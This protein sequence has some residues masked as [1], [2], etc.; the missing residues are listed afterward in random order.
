MTLALSCSCFLCFHDDSG[1]LRAPHDTLLVVDA[2]VGRNA[3]DQA[4]T[5]KQEVR[6]SERGFGVNR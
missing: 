4:R 5:W 3:V 1:V 2:S 6:N